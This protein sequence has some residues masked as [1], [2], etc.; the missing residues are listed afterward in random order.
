M[1]R[2]ICLLIFLMAIR[3]CHDS[4]SEKIES[5]I[6]AMH[7]KEISIPLDSFQCYTGLKERPITHNEQSKYK[8]VVFIDSTECS[9]CALENMH[10]WDSYVHLSD[11]LKNKFNIDFIISPKPTEVEL[12]KIKILA[13]NFKHAIY[14]D[15]QNAFQKANPIIPTD[16][17]YHTFLLDKENKIILVGNPIHN[18]KIH[19]L[20]IDYIKQ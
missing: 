5:T 19:Q 2:I 15:A 12:A 20:L 16:K 1:S 4:N 10:E 3:G 17:M 7:G 8:L 13:E 18:K 11:S 6:S 14:I 9:S